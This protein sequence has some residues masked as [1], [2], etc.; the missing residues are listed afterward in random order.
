M[1]RVPRV[2]GPG[3]ELR[4][5]P[6]AYQQAPDALGAAGATRA[7]QFGQ[8][9]QIANEYG[10]RVQD[11][12]DQARFDDARNQLLQ[13]ETD[14]TYG[15]AGYT[16]QLGAAALKRDS[17]QPLAVEYTQKL[18]QRASE[19][20]LALGNARQKQAFRAFSG[21][22]LT[23]FNRK[24]GAFE[25]EQGRVYQQSVNEGT[26]TLAQQRMGMSWNDP[27]IVF[28]SR[29][30]IVSAVGKSASA[31]GM[32]VEAARAAAVAALSP[33]HAAVLTS[34]ID[35]G[36][37]EFARTY[38]AQAAPELLPAARLQ[39]QKALD[40]GTADA[41]EQEITDRL[42]S[43]HEGNAE[44]ALAEARATL[45]G[46]D[47][48]AVVQRIQA[49]D[50]ERQTFKNRAE[51]QAYDG[52]LRLVET[53]RPVPPSMLAAMG[54]G[55]AAALLQ[56][57][58][59]RAKAAA[60]EAAGKS[61]KTD[62][63]LYLTL[64]EQAVEEP[65]AFRQLDLTRFIDR[66]GGAQLEQLADLKRGMAQAANKPAKAPRDAVTLTQQMNATLAAL[67]ITNKVKRGEF[68]GFV[69]GEVDDAMQAKGGKPLTYDERQQI[70][71]RAVMKGPD[72]DAW[73]ITP[74][75]LVSDRRMFE[76]TPEQR[77]RFAPNSTTPELPVIKN[78][79]DFAALPSGAR[80]KAPDGSIR[81][82]P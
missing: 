52:A 10:V 4:A 3:V 54:D 45:K 28:E 66:I 26:I 12:Q 74:A 41:R 79:D 38:M 19:I 37:L 56:H 40:V 73:G 7:R 17:G 8:V 64:R 14:L 42:W 30:A 5:A 49:R 68:M 55:H 11:E 9:A 23:G 16:K 67:K 6:N 63:A 59:A 77:K 50:T 46:K 57:Q 75:F 44:A 80:F 48:D 39:L 78:D 1:P 72:P 31:A 21:G 61:V 34:A 62:W 71:D 43:K 81:V 24:V 33:G 2:E 36:N 32:P 29:E 69:Q 53:G 82:K 13:A 76:L 58:R 51:R 15:D 25:G 20:E 70:I 35:S 22:T 47:E 60:S 27:Q 65:E 18:K